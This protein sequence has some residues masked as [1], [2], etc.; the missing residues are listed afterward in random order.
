MTTTS[1]TNYQVKNGKQKKRMW[2][3]FSILILAV[4]L[5]S[6][7]SFEIRDDIEI[8]DSPDKVWKAEIDFDNYKLWNSQLTFLG[9]I[10]EPNGKLHL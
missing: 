7:T 10:V 1:N 3:I 4:I 8:N 2:I 6:M 9:G 5:L